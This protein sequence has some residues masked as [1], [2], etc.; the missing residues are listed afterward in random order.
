MTTARKSNSTFSP[1]LTAEDIRTTAFPRNYP[2]I[3]ALIT[4]GAAITNT[5][6]TV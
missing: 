3:I 6:F 2:G 4:G 1:V 5:A